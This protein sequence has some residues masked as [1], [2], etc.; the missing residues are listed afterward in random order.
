[1]ELKK[2][3]EQILVQR[4]DKQKQK[5]KKDQITNEVNVYL[6]VEFECFLQLKSVKLEVEAAEEKLVT[7]LN[8]LQ[9]KEKDFALNVV[10]CLTTFQD[11]FKRGLDTLTSNLLHLEDKVK[12]S[13][14]ARVYGEHL[15]VH[16]R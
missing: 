5:E 3:E 15:A 7:K 16:L 10:K 6:D 4:L 11:Y 1:M 9:A 12:N 13:K 8:D 2:K 14:R